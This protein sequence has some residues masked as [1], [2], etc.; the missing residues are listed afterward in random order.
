MRFF[1]EA[2]AIFLEKSAGVVSRVFLAIARLIRQGPLRSSLPGSVSNESL[3]QCRAI[4][5][6]TFSQR[7]FSD[8]IPLVRSLRAADIDEPIYVVINGDLHGKYDVN[9]RA[10]FFSELST[11][12][13][14]NPISFGT[15]RG[16]ASMW[17]AGIRYSDAAEIVVLN[18]DVLV[19]PSEVANTLALLFEAIQTSGLVTLASSF[20]HF[21]ISRR[22]VD[23]IG[24]FDERFLGFGEEDG[25][26]IWRYEEH[27]GKAVSNVVAFGFINRA[28]DLGHESV[29][30]GGK[31]YSLFN[32]LYLETKYNFGSGFTRGIFDSV[33]T[34]LLPE[35]DPFT[36]DRFRNTL[37]S[38]RFSVSESEVRTGIRNFIHSKTNGES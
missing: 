15:Q 20:G 3:G 16:V 34:K 9:L 1:G 36:T 26:Y 10:S 13:D 21:G 31:K 35:M 32:R 28:S 22:C 19:N 17:N 14:V 37:E 18:D 38:E 25:D 4:V 6:T 24:W 33:A 30:T 7:F 11:L 23:D 12:Q 29:I 27:Y 8:C 5:I 2:I